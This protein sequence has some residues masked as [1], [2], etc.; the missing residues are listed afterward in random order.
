MSIDESTYS[1]RRSR[2][3][4]LM[5]DAGVD[6]VFLPPSADL[7]YLTGMQR[8]VPAFGSVGYAH[9]WVAGAFFSPNAEPVFV[10][11]RMITE[12]DLPDGV[13][14]EVVTVDET[15]DGAALMAGVLSR[16]GQVRTLAFGNRAWAQ[17]VL[18]VSTLA[19]PDRTLSAEFLL[20]RM[21]RVKSEDELANM[22]RACDLVDQVMADVETKVL[23]GV[24]ELE[25]AAEVAYRMKAAGSRTESFDTGVWSMGPLDQRDATV[26]VSDQPLRAGMGVSFDFGAVVD[27]YCSDFGRTVHIGEPNDGVRRSTPSSWPR[28]RLGSTP[29]ARACRPRRTCR[30][31]AGHRRRR[32][33][34]LVP[35]PDRP[36][37]RAGRARAARTSP[38]RTRPHSRPA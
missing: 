25:L 12:F 26:R 14:G 18:E 5:E 31:P 13:T 19:R 20:N 28:S 35:A 11:P 10:L 27:G 4:T 36:L 1:S 17:T 37:H 38:R 30:Y 2:L 29:C 32:L 21:R 6:L 23:P 24:T 7:E 15:A 8:R 22:K 16:F 9:H 33:R 34:R 3:A